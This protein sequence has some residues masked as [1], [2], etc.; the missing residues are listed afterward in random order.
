MEPA[1]L[2]RSAAACAALLLLAPPAGAGQF[3]IGVGAE[4]TSG[5]YGGSADVHE[6]Y[7]PLMLGYDTRRLGLRLSIPYVHLSAPADTTVL[8]QG[9][10]RIV[11]VPGG[12]A[13]ETHSGLGNV[14]A[15]ATLYDVVAAPARGLFVDVTGRVKLGTADADAGLGS[16]ENDYALEASAYQ[17]LGHAT[18]I[19]TLGYELNGDPPG[20]NLDNVWYGTLG[21]SMPWTQ[22]TRA[23][24]F[25]DFAQAPLAGQDGPRELSLHVAHRLDPQ[26][27]VNAY[28]LTGL[29]DGSPDW[30]AGVAFIRRF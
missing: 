13:R 15:S 26:R 12:G 6:I 18:G 16:G 24:L 17:R 22:Q 29:S 14:R 3:R 30:G 2:R 11:L 5:D 4:Y 1:S 25:F 19:A 20:T 8:S 28:A 21:A 27:S 23:G 7:A 10:R 9:D